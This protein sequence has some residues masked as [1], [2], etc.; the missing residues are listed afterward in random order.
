M[1]KLHETVVGGTLDELH[2]WL[3]AN[4]GQRRGELVLIVAGAEPT[5]P[6]EDDPDALLAALLEDLP[7]SRAVSVAARVTG[8]R[9]N[10]LYRRAVALGGGSG[11]ADEEE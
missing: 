7:V 4:P 5:Q 9:R 6:S 8:A 2:G 11:G 1:T 10:A 3:E